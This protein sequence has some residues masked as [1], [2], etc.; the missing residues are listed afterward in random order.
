MNYYFPNKSMW[1]FK[2]LC[3][4]DITVPFSTGQAKKHKNAMSISLL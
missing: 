4:N 3:L 2:F 1:E